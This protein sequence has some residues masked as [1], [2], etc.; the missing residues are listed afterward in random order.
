MLV[1]VAAGIGNRLL[2]AL[3]TESVKKYTKLSKHLLLFKKLKAIVEF[4]NFQRIKVLDLMHL[5]L[6]LI[7][8]DI[9]HYI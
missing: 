3:V 8:N 5:H 9:Q 7:S 1:Y 2:T 4:Q 6:V